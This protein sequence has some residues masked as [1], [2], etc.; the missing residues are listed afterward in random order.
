MLRRL[1][2]ITLLIT[3]AGLL[4]GLGYAGLRYREARQIRHTLYDAFEPVAV[5]N[6]ELKRF[7]DPNDGGY[8][9]CG[10]L[11][12]GAQVAYSYGI[13]GT[14][15]WGCQI[16]TALKVGVHQYDCFN[17]VVPYCAG[18]ETHFHPEC[19][20]PEPS[21][22]EGR[23]F[24]SVANQVSKNGDA[25]KRI[26]M[27][28]DVEGS[29]WESL[30]KTPD[31]VLTDI[32]QIAIEFHEV[33]KPTFLATVERLKQFFYIA[34]LHVNNFKC[35]PGFEPFSGQVFEALLVSKRLGQID[36]KINARGPSPLDAPNTPTVPD[37]QAPPAGAEVTKMA[38][39]TGRHVTTWFNNN[40]D[41]WKDRL[42]PPY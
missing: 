21:M 1:M 17:P 31:A 14:D 35:E 41:T 4:A 38:R 40:Y 19:V 42:L 6:C 5:T 15:N 7:G 22:F 12:G 37:C 39:W 36:P 26:V 29:E 25:G 23:P 3:L 30:V 10:N 16:S 34:H 27:K 32:D 28:M 8:L 20:G 18:G 33:E 9:L 2:R 11:L 13:N 24:D